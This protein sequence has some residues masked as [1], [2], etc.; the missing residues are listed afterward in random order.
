MSDSCWV[1]LDHML[2]LTPSVLTLSMRE[3]CDKSGPFFTL[4]D[5][6]EGARVGFAVR[7][8]DRLALS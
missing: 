4:I 6:S 7:C 3:E 5:Q 2:M 8:N 1:C